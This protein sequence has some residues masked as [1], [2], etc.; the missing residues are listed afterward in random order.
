MRLGLATLGDDGIECTS[1]V[2][3]QAMIKVQ[4]LS[5]AAIDSMF[6]NSVCQDA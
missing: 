6:R 4:H 1:N 2:A 3:H 5:V